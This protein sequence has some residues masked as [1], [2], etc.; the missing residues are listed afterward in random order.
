MIIF[1]N[2]DAVIDNIKQ[3]LKEE[4][5]NSKVEIG[6]PQMTPEESMQRI[7]EYFKKRETFTGKAKNF[8]ARFIYAAVT[9]IENINTEV[10]GME[11]LKV[12]DPQQGAIITSNHFNPL[13]N[14]IIRRFVQKTKTHKRLFIISQDTNLGMKG[15]VGFLMN[16]LDIIP[17][18]Q[19]INYLGHTFP[20]ALQKVIDEGNYI[21]IYPEEEMWFNYRKP[22]PF[23]RGTYY[24]AAKINAPIISCFV[25][26]QDLKSFE[27]NS[28]KKI[29][30]VK[31]TLHVLPIIF[32]D[33][34]KS[35]KENSIEM[36]NKDYQQKKAA[37]EKAYGK[38][39]TYDFD[40]SDIAG[41]VGPQK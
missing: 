30:R 32:P 6:D 7:T 24:Y 33:P 37:Y 19:S 12:L 18:S 21:L 36:M 16:N 29:H 26:M 25:E 17:M 9:W 39:L 34:N 41:W 8:C 23:K 20:K 27:P 5:Y 40:P 1:P 13:E 11:N 35:V 10:V 28:N 14:T 38:K 22:R 31:S 4:K 3:N 2:R 15:L